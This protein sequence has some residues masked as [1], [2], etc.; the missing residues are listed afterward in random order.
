[1]KRQTTDWGK[2]LA[3]H[4][5]YIGLASK[6]ALIKIKKKYICMYEYVYVY[7]PKTQ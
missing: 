2:I 1:M 4:V 3:N 6:N 7:T 5:F